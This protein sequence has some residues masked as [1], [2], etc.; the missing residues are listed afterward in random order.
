MDLLFV[1]CRHTQFD[2]TLAVLSTSKFECI[3]G[4]AC[5]EARIIID[6]PSWDK[7]EDNH[8]LSNTNISRIYINCNGESSC[9]D[10]VVSIIGVNNFDLDCNGEK[11]CGEISLSMT[12]LNEKSSGSVNMNCNGKLSCEFAIINGIT[13]QNVNLNC[14][15]E[16][17]SCKET[18]VI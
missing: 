7:S 4:Y 11:S 5:L 1:A 13:L 6:T 17:D 8:I 14:N 9:E 10:A 15:N 2:I 3:G 12:S 18:Q 16:Q